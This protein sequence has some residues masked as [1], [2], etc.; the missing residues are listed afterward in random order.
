MDFVNPLS[1]NPSKWANTLRGFSRRIVLIVFGHFVGSSLKGLMSQY[2][3]KKDG[4][5][6]S[7]RNIFYFIL[8]ETRHYLVIVKS[9]E[10]L[11]GRLFATLIRFFRMVHF[12][13]P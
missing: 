11:S 6:Q 2:Y 1:T 3:Y 10:V 13:T 5:D 8:F 9:K 7:A 4:F 12:Y